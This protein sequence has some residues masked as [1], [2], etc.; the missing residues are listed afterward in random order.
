[1]VHQKGSPSE[2][3]Q[4]YLSDTWSAKADQDRVPYPKEYFI[5]SHIY[6]DD[7]G[8]PEAIRIMGSMGGGY[9][10]IPWNTPNLI[11]RVS[12]KM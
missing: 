11:K 4:F 2:W 1:M 3:T 7:D 6:R 5:V 9:D 12:K 8:K 10:K